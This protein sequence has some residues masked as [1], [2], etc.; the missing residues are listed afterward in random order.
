MGYFDSDMEEMLEVYLLETAQLLEQ[1]D[2][3]LMGAEQEKALS[4]EDINGIFRVMHTIKSSSAMMGLEGLSSLAH[5]MED[6]FAV[7]REDP[8]RLHGL[9]QE[10]FDLLFEGGDIFREEMGRMG[11]ETYQPSDASDF[12]ARIKQLL[13]KAKANKKTIVCLRFEPGCKMENIRAYMVVRQI[14]GLCSEITMYP[15]HVDTNPEAEAYVRQ[16]GF[17]IR[18]LSEQPD[19]VLTRLRDALFVESLDIVEDMPRE[20]KEQEQVSVQNGSDYIHVRVGKLDE[21]QNLTGELLIA[22]QAAGLGAGSSSPGMEDDGHSRQLERL[23]KELEEMVI[24]IRMVPFSLVVP[25]LNRMVRDMCRKEKKEVSFVV[26]GQEVELDKKVADSVLEPLLHL[27]RNAIDH[28]IETPDIRRSAGKPETGKV[29][30]KLSNAGGEIRISVMDDGCGIDPAMLLKK[31]REKNLLKEPEETYS[32]QELLELCLL[33]GFSTRESANEYSGRGVGLDVVHQMVERFGGHLHLSSNKGEGSR[34][35]MYLP[36]TLTIMDC[37]RVRAGNS[38]FAVPSHQVSQFFSYRSAKT[39]CQNGREYWI[40]EGRYIQV[41]SL[42]R[43]FDMQKEEQRGG[44]IMVY[45]SGSTREACLL[46]DQIVDSGSLVEKPLPKILGSG[47]RHYTG[48]SGCSL[49]ADGSVCMQV[50]IEDFI[51]VAGGGRVYE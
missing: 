9:E 27:L 20:Q 12:E 5:R 36:L 31:A 37:V 50:D 4:R 1:A 43:F 13:A 38:V 24:A 46:V 51:R 23:L 22:A 11:Q 47:F 21:L 33:P 41:I 8:S 28:G 18:F 10:T 19:Q 25:K 6:V 32:S 2:A 26:E 48:L 44:Q 3:I 39:V 14:K 49:L 45:V 7:F 40:Y 16:N 34:F 29:S 15:E 42:R 35:T 17:F 30:V